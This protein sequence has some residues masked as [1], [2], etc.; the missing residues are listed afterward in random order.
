MYVLKC[1]DLYIKKGGFTYE[2]KEAKKYRTKKEAMKDKVSG[3]V[4]TKIN[5]RAFNE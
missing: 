2:V 5:R 4:V 1:L 3:W